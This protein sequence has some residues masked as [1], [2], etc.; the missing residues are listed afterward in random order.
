[1]KG[2]IGF[3]RSVRSQ[4]ARENGLMTATD[5]AKWVKQWKQYAGCTAKHI[6]LNLIASEW[7]HTSKYFNKT[8]YYD[9]RDLLAI[10]LRQKLQ[11][12]L[13]ERKLAKKGKLL[14]YFKEEI[15]K[16][17]LIFQERYMKD[18]YYAVDS[19]GRT[20]GC[21]RLVDDKFV[22]DWVIGIEWYNVP[23]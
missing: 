9:P 22:K 18:V 17:G 1:M 11:K 20:H 14:D 4:I 2:Y 3:S 6:S 10:D 8:N 15:E 5:L 7:H 19:E 16:K 21:C 13:L 23:I 12:C